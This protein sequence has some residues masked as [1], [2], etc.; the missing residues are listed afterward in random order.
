MGWTDSQTDGLSLQTD[1][2]HQCIPPPYGGGDI[3]KTRT[4]SVQNGTVNPLAL[5]QYRTWKQH[6]KRWGIVEPRSPVAA[7]ICRQDMVEQSHAECLLSLEKLLQIVQFAITINSNV[8]PHIRVLNTLMRESY[9][10]RHRN[11]L[12]P[13]HVRHLCSINYGYFLG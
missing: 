10:W 3:I 6:L 5:Q 12:F 8:C 9:A 11:T 1:N 2:G 7:R 4:N 13:E